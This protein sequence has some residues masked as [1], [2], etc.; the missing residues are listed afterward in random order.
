MRL[1]FFNNKED[2]EK[3]VIRWAGIT[4]LRMFF[5]QRAPSAQWFYVQSSAHLA[6][7]A[8]YKI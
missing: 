8:Q 5:M 2:A 3:D 1:T 7:S 6:L 4:V